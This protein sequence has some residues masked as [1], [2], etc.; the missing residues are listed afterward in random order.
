MAVTA[1]SGMVIYDT[2][3]IVGHISAWAGV[4]VI[5][6]AA[7]TVIAFITRKAVLPHVNIAEEVDKQGNVAVGAIEAAV[8]VA[9]GF[10]LAGLF[11]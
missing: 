9:V 3:S 4:A 8:Y 6:M 2:E 11:G 10:L 1:A 7:L 5:M